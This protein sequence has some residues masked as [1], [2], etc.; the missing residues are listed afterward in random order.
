[1]NHHSG[2]YRAKSISRDHQPDDSD[3]RHAWIRERQRRDV[4]EGPT[5][6]QASAA[7][8]AD[9]IV[10][11]NQSHESIDTHVDV[12]LSETPV[13]KGDNSDSTWPTH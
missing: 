7:P 8:D 1:M 5:D 3:R 11:L 12:P 6:V 10:W 4:R 9:R 2:F 13:A